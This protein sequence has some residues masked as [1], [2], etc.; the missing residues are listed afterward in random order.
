MENKNENTLE[1]FLL[2]ESVTVSVMTV[3]P[4]IKPYHYDYKYEGETKF[5]EAF[6]TSIAMSV[7]RY[8]VVN[9]FFQNKDSNFKQELTAAEF[10]KYLAIEMLR[11]SLALFTKRINL[12]SK[13]FNLEKAYTEEQV[14]DEEVNEILNAYEDGSRYW[15]HIIVQQTEIEN[16]KKKS[17]EHLDDFGSGNPTV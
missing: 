2:I 14:T 17:V 5:V 10:A 1:K 4:Y 11:S 3:S 8:T 13:G 6:K 12:H 9:L 15:K 16:A 7:N